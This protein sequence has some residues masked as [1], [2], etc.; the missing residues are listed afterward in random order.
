M[1]HTSHCFDAVS[2]A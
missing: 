2:A 1:I